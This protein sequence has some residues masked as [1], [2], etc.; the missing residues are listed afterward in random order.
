[1]GAGFILVGFMTVSFDDIRPYGP[2]PWMELCDPFLLVGIALLVPRMLGNR[3][4]LPIAY[5]IGAIGMLTAGTLS[6]LGT[7]QP[8]ANFEYFLD[9]VRGLVFLPVFIAWWQPG[10]RTVVA[11]ALAYLVGNSINVVESLIEGPGMWG[12]RYAGFTSH[13]NTMGICQVLGISLL[14][15]L[16][17][18]LPRRHHW[19]VGVLALMSFYG[20]WITGSRAA[21]ASAVLL[22][23]MY[24]MLSRSIPAALAVAS[25]GFVALSIAI[26]L[27][28]TADPESTLGRLL[29]EGS[30]RGSNESRRKGAQAGLDQFVHHPLLGDGWLS[31][32]QNHD[33][34]IQVAAAIGFFGLV[35]Y[36]LILVGLLRPLLAVPRPYG[37]LATPALAVIM[38]DV[39]LPV[40]G[41]R[42]VWVVVGLALS[43]ERLATLAASDDGDPGPGLLHGRGSPGAVRRLPHGRTAVPSPQERRRARRPDE[44]IR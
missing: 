41:A 4:N 43:A 24:P 29:G 6:A 23:V 33:A 38:L 26:R 3:L 16:L 25:L 9:I 32:W 42:F 34:Y 17:E 44:M 35:S 21:L 20:V 1:M 2:A 40:L 30:A 15:F 19:I 31:T 14:P 18:A 10:R 12:S 36:L 22:A 28:E 39:F 8:G 7:E 5:L 37:L 13:P 27:A 11:L